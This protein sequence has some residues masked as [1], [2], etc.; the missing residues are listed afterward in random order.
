MLLLLE[1]NPVVSPFYLPLSSLKCAA[2]LIKCRIDFID[3]SVPAM[4]WSCVWWQEGRQAMSFFFRSL[5]VFVRI[6][7]VYGALSASEAAVKYTGP[8][9]GLSQCNNP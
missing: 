9:K 6:M 5:P 3:F 2:V 8:P 7:M 4:F 1:P